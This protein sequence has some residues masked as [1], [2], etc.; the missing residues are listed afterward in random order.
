MF[1]HPIYNKRQE[2][3][4]DVGGPSKP[5]HELSSSSSTNTAANCK[6]T[7]HVQSFNLLWKQVITYSCTTSIYY[8]SYKLHLVGYFC[9]FFVLIIPA[10]AAL[11]DIFP[12]WDMTTLEGI[13]QRCGGVVSDAVDMVFAE[14]P[15]MN[16]CSNVSS[17][18]TC[19]PGNYNLWYC[20]NL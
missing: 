1:H 4:K 11:Q 16:V 20:N 2:I 9:C 12:E 6:Y 14:F 8:D 3:G 7:F 5:N 18:A 13:L 17:T 19:E 15:P 10:L